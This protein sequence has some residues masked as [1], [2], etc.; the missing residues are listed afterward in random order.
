M[1]E[2]CLKYWNILAGLALLG[3]TI[4]AFNRD[5]RKLQKKSL[6]ARSN[7]SPNQLPE[8]TNESDI[9]QQLV[10]TALHDDPPPLKLIQGTTQIELPILKATGE[11]ALQ[12]WVD[13]RSVVD[14]T[15]FWPV[16][17][18]D[19]YEL[20][21]AGV[22]LGEA[23][24]SIKSTL[25]AAESIDVRTWIRKRIASNPDY[26][27]LPEGDW[28]E[29]EFGLNDFSSNLE[30]LAKQ[31]LPEVFLALVPTK[32]S[33]EVPA[34]LQFGGWNDIP[35]PEASVAILKHWNELYGAE[36]VAVQADTIEIHVLRPPTQKR[37]AQQL[38]KEHSAYCRDVFDDHT[39]GSIGAILRKSRVWYFW[40]D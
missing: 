25:L 40:W 27:K 6:E 1:I 16:I 35:L 9:I 39:V 3:I 12:L 2:W 28:P 20:E 38:A 13:L 10:D 34:Y 15:G 14:A 11:K 7:Q 36:L 24:E 21:T 4:F 5:Y 32:N 17:L 31:P 29:D 23:T 22:R 37:T 18:G 30:D 19:R 26:Y 8:M 33:W